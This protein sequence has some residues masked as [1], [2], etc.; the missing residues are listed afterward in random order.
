VLFWLIIFSTKFWTFVYKMPC[1]NYKQ[2]SIRQNCSR[3]EISSFIPFREWWPCHQKPPRDSSLTVHFSRQIERDGELRTN[4]RSPW[5]WDIRLN[6]SIIIIVGFAKQTWYLRE[7]SNYK[8]P[9][10]E[11]VQNNAADLDREPPPPVSKQNAPGV[12]V[13][14]RVW[15]CLNTGPADDGPMVVVW[16]EDLLSFAYI[17]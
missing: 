17:Q 9:S 5:R 2:T 7:C 1:K 8:M 6:I 4:E 12:C 3:I 14:V 15:I 16:I 13:W 11:P 10:A